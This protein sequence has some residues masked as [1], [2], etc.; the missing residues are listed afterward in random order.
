MSLI[1]ENESGVT[2]Y[3]FRQCIA[4][5]KRGSSKIKK[6]DIHLF[7][8]QHQIRD[9][10]LEFAIVI[11]NFVLL[12]KLGQPVGDNLGESVSTVCHHHNITSS[13]T[14]LQTCSF[15]TSR[16]PGEEITRLFTVS[17]RNS[18]SLVGG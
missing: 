17:N 15:T 4:T 1:N 5:S 3:L 2:K 9:E 13:K 16:P 14:S 18:K 7:F 11:F 8:Q 10:I 12:R 6:L